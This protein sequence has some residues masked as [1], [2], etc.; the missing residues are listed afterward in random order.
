VIRAQVA[1]ALLLV[2]TANA[3][4]PG[5]SEPLARHRAATIR[6]VSYALALD[7]IT[8]DSAIGQVTVRFRRSGTGD[9]IIDFRGRRLTKSLANGHPIPS[10]AEQNGHI[11]IP[12]RPVERAGAA[13]AISDTGSELGGALGIAIL[14]SIGTAVYRGAIVGVTPDGISRR[15]S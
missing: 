14:G 5:I 3:Q 11:R 1:L 2:A 13:S 7:V 10:G 4:A 15:R 9:A 12:A 6:D 8:L